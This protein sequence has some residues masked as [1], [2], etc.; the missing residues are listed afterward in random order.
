MSNSTYK[1]D[2][3]N[4]IETRIVNGKEKTRIIP[5]YDKYGEY[6]KELCLVAKKEA[7]KQEMLEKL[8]AR[9]QETKDLFASVAKSPEANKM[10]SKEVAS[11]EEEIV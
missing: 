7:A 10:G 11:F 6:T 3:N 9:K 4:L 5:I 8:Q 1:K 2:G